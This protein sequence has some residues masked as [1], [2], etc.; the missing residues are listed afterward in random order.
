MESEGADNK[1]YSCRKW[2]VLQKI[3]AGKKRGPPDCSRALIS[4]KVK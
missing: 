1:V 4:V 2:L 3:I